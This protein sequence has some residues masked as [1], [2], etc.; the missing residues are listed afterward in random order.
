MN[1]PPVLRAQ[2]WLKRAVRTL[3]KCKEPVGLGAK[4]VITGGSLIADISRLY[5]FE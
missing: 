3:P 4:R 2:R 1:F 5:L